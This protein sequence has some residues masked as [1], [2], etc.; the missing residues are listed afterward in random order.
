[1]TVVCLYCHCRIE[2]QGPSAL[3]VGRP[4]SRDERSALSH[5]ICWPCFRREF[6]EADAK[7]AIQMGVPHDA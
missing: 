1:M 5:G 3:P 2:G 4:L 7:D 6:S